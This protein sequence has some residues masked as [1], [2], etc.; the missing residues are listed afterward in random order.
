MA[1]PSGG[2]PRILGCDHIPDPSRKVTHPLGVTNTNVTWDYPPKCRM[3]IL[4]NQK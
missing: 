4:E 2:G 3:E 1:S